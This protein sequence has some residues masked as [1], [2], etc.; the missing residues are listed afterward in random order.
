MSQDKLVAMR[1]LLFVLGFFKNNST[2]WM[3]WYV[4]RQIDLA[5]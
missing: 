3:L 1:S 5:W 4:I 2:V